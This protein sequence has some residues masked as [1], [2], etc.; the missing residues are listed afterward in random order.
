VVRWS[1]AL[2]L[3]TLGW[4]SGA[5]A[6]ELVVRDAEL[7]DVPLAPAA[8]E[9]MT[10][11]VRGSVWQRFGVDL[12]WEGNG[13]EVWENQTAARLELEVKRSQ[14]LRFAVGA[15]LYH[16]W[17]APRER[18][19]GLD[20]SRYDLLLRPTA[21][22]VDGTP[23]EGLHVRAGYQ[24]VVMGRFD[25]FSAAD[26]L[27]LYDLSRGITSDPAML[28]RAQLAA[29]I[30]WDVRP[31]FSLTAVYLPIFEPHRIAGYGT[32]TSAVRGFGGPNATAAF[33]VL[34]RLFRRSFSPAL[35]A[36]AVQAMGTDRSFTN[37]QAAVRMTARLPPV[38]V[39]LTGA[40]V[41]DHLPAIEV[42][43]RFA[44]YLKNPTLATS[45]P[46]AEALLDRGT[47]PITVT[48]PRYAVAA[49]D[50]S[51]HVGPLLV[52]GEAAITSRRNLYAADPLGA[53]VPVPGRSPLLQTALGVEY[54]RGEELFVSVE[55]M[56]IHALTDSRLPGRR[57]MGFIDGR[58]LPGALL[59]ARWSVGAPLTLG[60]SAVA[61]P[62]PSAFVMPQI[63]WRLREGLALQTGLFLVYGPEMGSPWA[64]SLSL[65]GLFDGLDQAYAG[66]RWAF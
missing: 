42:S 31:W 64:S 16:L 26:A 22:Y 1:V 55:G 56:M 57:W 36:D 24:T 63:E 54:V 53:E 25:L 30:D 17:A 14:N 28:R 23:A 61:L 27:A 44:R 4:T 65:G 66:L 40:A 12:G 37:P 32:D 29:R 47:P 50:A 8:P 33:A 38:E 3:A 43:D 62:G 7:G 18:D 13:E 9:P 49:L 5:V 11:T 48:Y 35:T 21:A 59:T 34:D 41:V 39:S 6:D 51:T 46:P 10:A 19:G 58:T 15:E 52:K 60:I 2:A 20:R 45:L